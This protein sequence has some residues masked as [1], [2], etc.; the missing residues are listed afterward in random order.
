[1]RSWAGSP[2]HARIQTRS[3][4]HQIREARHYSHLHSMGRFAGYRVT[5]RTILSLGVMWRDEG[6][7]NPVIDTTTLGRA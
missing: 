5:T 7:G 4:L 6:L 1:M 2:S 3:N